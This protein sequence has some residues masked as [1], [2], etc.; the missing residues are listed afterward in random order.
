MRGLI[1]GYGSIGRRHARNWAAL[2]LGPL[3]VCPREGLADAL[4]QRPDVVL[5]TNPTSLHVATV[6]QALEAG[7]H[8]LVEKPLGSTLEGV[9]ALLEQARRVGRILAVGYTFR[10]HPGLSRL[11]ELVRT[12]AIGAI[13]SARAEAGEYLPDWHPWEDYRHSYS[14]RRDLGGGVVLTL[15]HE[16]DSLCW[17]LGPPRRLTAFAAHASRLEIDTE[18][19]ADILLELAGPTLAAIHVDY[20][21]RA[22]RRALELVGDEGVLRWEYEANR[23]LRFEPATRQWR[24]EQGDPRFERNQMFVDELRAFARTVQDGDAAPTPLATGEQGA[25]ILAV[26]LAALQS[27]RDGQ[28]V[29]FTHAEEPIESWLKSLGR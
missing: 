17:L 9:P 28:A 10:F 19:V 26:A 15:S 29:D 7:A 5:V 23:V 22:P 8:V 16:L 14:G 12:N 3:D 4:R 25:A 18:D 13:V 24:L 1:V 2:E 21:R 6:C 20:V 11:K 27:A